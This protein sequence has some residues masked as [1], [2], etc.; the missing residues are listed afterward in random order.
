MARIPSA[1]VMPNT[2][3]QPMIAAAA[4]V[5]DLVSIDMPAAAA[6]CRAFLIC[7]AVGGCGADPGPHGASWGAN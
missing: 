1:S 4:G 3:A 6:V 7:A 5:L 2:V